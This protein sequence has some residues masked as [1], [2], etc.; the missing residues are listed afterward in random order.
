LEA[1]AAETADSGSLEDNLDD[2][3][4]DHFTSDD[5]ESDADS[6]ET[7]DDEESVHNEETV[8]DDRRHEGSED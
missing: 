3:E 7:D 6:A 4:A 1:G 5:A 2:A 8:H